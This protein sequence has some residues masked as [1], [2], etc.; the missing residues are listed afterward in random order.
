MNVYFNLQGVVM[1]PMKRERSARAIENCG[2]AFLTKEDVSE[3]ARDYPTMEVRLRN[4]AIRYGA[5]NISSLY[6]KNNG[7]CYNSEFKM[8]R[9]QAGG[10]GRC[11][12]AEGQYLLFITYLLFICI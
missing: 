9:D 1:R 2:L 8:P 12:A 3:V 4:L 11:A 6:K 10:E 5:P 7:K